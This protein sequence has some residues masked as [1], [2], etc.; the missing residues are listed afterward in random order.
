MEINFWYTLA[1]GLCLYMLL[2]FTRTFDHTIDD[3]ILDHCPGWVYKLDLCFIMAGAFLLI[4]A[5]LWF[6][7]FMYFGMEAAG[8][9]MWGLIMI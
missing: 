8:G 4:S 2:T 7:L 6:P 3:F 5:M 1:L 9:R